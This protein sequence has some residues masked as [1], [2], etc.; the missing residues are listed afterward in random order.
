VWIARRWQNTR[1]WFGR[2]S[3]LARLLVIAVLLTS[4]CWIGCGGLL[5]HSWYI[6]WIVYTAEDRAFLRDRGE[7]KEGVPSVARRLSAQMAQLRDPDAALDYHPDW[8]AIRCLNGEWLFG[9]GVNSHG[10]APGRGTLVLKDSRGRV[11]VFFGHICGMN[12]DFGYQTDRRQPETIDSYYQ[13]L[14]EA[15]SDLREWIPE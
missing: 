8:F 4:P 2:R 7:Y 14:K 3:L 9:Y 12:A 11:R 10:F 15:H 13:W 6:H 1:A 5:F